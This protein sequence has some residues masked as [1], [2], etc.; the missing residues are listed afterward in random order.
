MAFVRGDEGSVS[1]EKDGGTVAAV[2]GTRSWSL[3]ITKD[4]IDTTKQGDT[5]RSFIGSQ[6]SGSGTVELL[7]DNAASGAVADLMD[8]VLVGTDQ[9]NAKFELFADTTNNKSFVFNGI[10]TS[11]DAAAASGDLQVIT[12]NF[13]TSGD[14]TSGI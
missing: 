8:E 2:A 10:I 5:S 1:F 6:I 12:C 13:I 14:I 11:M 3:N 7:Y 4:T 9:A